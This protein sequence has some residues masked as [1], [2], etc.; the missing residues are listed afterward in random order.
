MQ[1]KQVH[2]GDLDA[3]GKLQP[4]GWS[5]IV[6]SFQFYLENSF[7]LPMK[8]E[9]DGK[10]A[11][12]GAI[13]FFERTAWIAHLIVAKEHRGKGMGRQIMEALIQTAGQKSVKT[14]SL[15][16]TEM[17]LPLYQKLGF[18]L[19]SNYQEFE[20]SE[21]FKSITVSEKV[22]PFTGEFAEQLFELDKKLSSEN[23]KELLKQKFSGSFLYADDQSN[24]SG[25]YLPSLGEG[26]ICAKSE[27]AGIEL[28]KLKINT[29]EKLNL[30][31]ENKKAIAFLESVGFQQGTFRQRMS[32]GTPLA[33]SAQTLFS[34]IAGKLG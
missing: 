19:I 8:A 2:K 31:S 25:Y 11:G 13:I 34:R 3:I 9:I 4:E 5:A 27:E 29:S 30:P 24:I 26:L 32:L 7:C 17:G 16:A 28:L 18:R 21:K 6:P 10:I 1:L 22:I 33:W 23:R 20:K 12:I 15:I 14:I